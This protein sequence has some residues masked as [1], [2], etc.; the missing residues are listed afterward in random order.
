[1]SD[2]EDI[3]LLQIK[4]EGLLI[5]E[6]EYKFHRHR[7]WKFDFAYPCFKLAFEVEGGLWISGRH[8][9]GKGF[10]ADIEKYNTAAMM[11]W[12]V[13]RLHSAP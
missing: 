3:L 4:R 10:I 7:R 5:P 1:M 6:R 11:G 12:R 2:I 8:N 9:R 13:F